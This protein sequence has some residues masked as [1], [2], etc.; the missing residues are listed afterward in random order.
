MKLSIHSSFKYVLPH[1]QDKKVL[2]IGC[3][4]GR[5]LKYFTN[6][7]IGIDIDT[8]ALTQCRDSGF[9]VREV[10]INQKGLPFAS[11][12]FDAIFCSHVLEH[13]DNPIQVLREANSILKE[14]GTLILG[15]P[16]ENNLVGTLLHEDYFLDHPG[17]LFSFS[18]NGA[19]ALL[20]ASGFEPKAVYFDLPRCRG[21][22]TSRLLDLYQ[23]LPIWLKWRISPAYWIVA[24]KARTEVRE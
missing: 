7:S 21:K 1:I 23:H 9:H 24:T 6:N 14:E 15:L 19:K 2:D 3:K 13:L 22:I 8:E 11:G 4:N 17:H 5:Y 20:K 12:S 10:D 16:V 18:V